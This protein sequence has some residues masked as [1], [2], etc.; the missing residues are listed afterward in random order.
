MLNEWSNMI[1]ER[2]P[3]GRVDNTRSMKLRKERCR[4]AQGARI[5][6]LESKINNPKKQIKNKANQKPKTTPHPK[7]L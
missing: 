4:L 3:H 6:Y 1:P 7:Q 2:G 5:V